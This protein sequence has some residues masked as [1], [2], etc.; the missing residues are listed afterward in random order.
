MKF[1]KNKEHIGNSARRRGVDTHHR[2]VV[3]V[4]EE[5]KKERRQ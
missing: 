3:H 1:V 2:S 4:N 5:L